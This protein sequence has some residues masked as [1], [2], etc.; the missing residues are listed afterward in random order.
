MYTDS[1]R[2][3]HSLLFVKSIPTIRFEDSRPADAKASVTYQ[4]EI[5]WFITFGFP[6]EGKHHHS[7]YVKFLIITCTQEYPL[8]K[9]KQPIKATQDFVLYRQCNHAVSS[10]DL[11]FHMFD[12]IIKK[13]ESPLHEHPHLMRVEEG[14]LFSV[15][16]SLFCIV[17]TTQTHDLLV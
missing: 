16:L 8:F 11:L 12:A 10:T 5:T 2:P 14:S 1:I 9:S 4:R 6:T 17:S 7:P 15:A 13:G 3:V